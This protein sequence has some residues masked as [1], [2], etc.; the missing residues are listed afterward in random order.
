MVVVLELFSGIGGMRCGLCE[1]VGSAHAMEFTSIDLN[2]FCNKV[3]CESFKDSPLTADICALSVEWFEKL[4]ADVWTMSPPCQPYSRQGK[5]LGSKDERA[6]P[7]HHLISV[8]DRL[9]H[10]PKLIIVENVKNFEESDSFVELK[11]VLKRKGYSL[12]GYLL[13]PLY[14]GFPNSRLRF[15]LVAILDDKNSELVI[16][17]NDPSY[18]EFDRLEA[19][20]WPQRTV[21]DF[22]CANHDQACGLEVPECILAK[23]ASFA[24]DIVSKHSQ[25]CLCFTRSYKKY[26]S[27]TGSVLVNIED[28][29]VKSMVTE[30][31]EK[32]R[33][34]FG[35]LKEM[36]EL[37]GTLRYFCPLEAARLN[38]F[39]VNHDAANW[40][41]RFR[42]ACKGNIQYY[43]A[44]GNSL[45]PHVVAFLVKRHWPF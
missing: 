29:H 2:E 38:G 44:V 1:A 6:R 14:M 18:P 28:P 16:Q 11:T 41:L 31:D 40:S 39:N 30:T 15:F 21:G 34:K 4:K 10:A 9:V 8:I 20:G 22:L 33:P 36:A 5:G 23:P 19:I 25:Q 13:N 7:L 43:R 26:I 45:N 35:N 24:F 42:D 17:C 37:T 3:Y 12:Y 27:G 32:Q